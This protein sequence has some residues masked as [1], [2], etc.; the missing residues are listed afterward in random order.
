MMVQPREF[1]SNFYILEEERVRQFLI[2]GEEEALLIDTGFG[3]SHVYDAVRSITDRPIQVLMTHGDPDHAG[4]LKDFGACRLHEGDWNLIRD[5]ISLKPLR[6][7]DGFRAGGYTLQVLEIPGHTYGSVAFVDWEKKLLL[8]GDSVQKDGPIYMF[9]SHR[10]LDLYLE[11]QKKLLS[12][13]DRIET[14]LPCHHDC[15][16]TPDYIEK[17][18]LD[19]QAL[20]EGQLTGKQHPI[21]PFRSYR[22]RW[23]EFYYD[24]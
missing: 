1:M 7:G 18:L 5:D 15:P 9:G 14:V 19:A 21:L 20:K 8:P 2:V 16:I 11:S 22:G 3:D 10:N 6:E 17:N 23:T 13:M 24:K 12:M 4:G